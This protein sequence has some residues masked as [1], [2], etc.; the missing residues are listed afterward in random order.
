MDYG[1]MN[2]QGLDQ[3]PCWPPQQFCRRQACQKY[4]P[5]PS[6]LGKVYEVSGGV[7]GSDEKTIVPVPNMESVATSNR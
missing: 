3:A 7:I 2:D 5:D 4:V 6:A 1:T